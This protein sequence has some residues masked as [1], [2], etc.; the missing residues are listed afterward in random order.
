MLLTGL[1]AAAGAWF[2]SRKAGDAN[3]GT[4]TV[5][6]E[7]TMSDQEWHKKLSPEQYAVLREKATEPAWTSPLLNEHEKGTFV[8]AGC[9]NALF[10][11]ATKYDS[12]SGWPSFWKPIAPDAIATTVDYEIGVPRTEVHCHRC[13]GHLG[14]VFDDGPAPTHLRYCMNGVALKFEPDGK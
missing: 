13:G 10:S 2:L 5:H 7:V 6:Y 8:C 3:S 4:P 11:S 9:A 12:G 1:T 14:H